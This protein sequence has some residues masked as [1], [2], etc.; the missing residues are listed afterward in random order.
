MTKLNDTLDSIKPDDGTV[1]D[2]MPS[3]YEE[4]VQAL[5]NLLILWHQRC[6]DR[7]GGRTINEKTE[8]CS[9]TIYVRLCFTHCACSACNYIVFL[10]SIML[11]LFA[12]CL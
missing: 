7:R 3:G 5:E 10:I 8:T 1:G 2:N 6:R 9:H 12:L 4:S 11:R